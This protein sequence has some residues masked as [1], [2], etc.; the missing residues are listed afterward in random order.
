MF[1]RIKSLKL[2]N[3]IIL[4]V[5]MLLLIL[6]A[7]NFSLLKYAAQQGLGQLRMVREAVPIDTLL[8]DPRYPDSLKTKLFLIKEIRR[9]A[10]DSL[11]LHDS[12]NYN[13]VYDL[14]GKP[15]AYVVQAAERYR[16]RKYLWKFPVV[17]AL[18]Y[19]GYFDEADAKAEQA[20]MESQGYDTRIAHPAGW[21]TMGWFKDP[22]LSSML[23]RDEASLAEL[24]IHELTHSTIFIKDDSDLN[25]NIADYVGENGAKCYLASKYGPQSSELQRY[26]SLISDNERLADYYLLGAHQLDSVYQTVA[27]MNM[28]V[29]DKDSA[30][31]A[32]IQQI[33]D[34]VDTLSLEVVN[35]W[36]LK[37]GRLRN[38]NN[39]FFTGYMTYYNKKN[40]LRKECADAFGGDF[41]R[42]L[43]YL[44]N[45]YGK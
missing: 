35:P 19:K 32:F 6:A 27:F 44:K 15:T 26:A 39:T 29:C 5:L 10:I 14:N 36:R 8:G 20:Y 43:A 3:K 40:Q 38:I 21:S 31:R 4:S 34:N 11:G 25:E 37:D 24:I 16:V 12:P 1:N 41:L 2:R 33:V 17:G 45:K 7:L 22:V 18:P 13:A 30:K 23:M 9:Y 42:F 28:Q